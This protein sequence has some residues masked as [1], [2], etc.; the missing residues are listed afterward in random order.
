MQLNLSNINA[1][2]EVLTRTVILS[3]THWLRRIQHDAEQ[4]EQSFSSYVPVFLESHAAQLF[5]LIKKAQA[6]PGAH[7]VS[8]DLALSLEPV[9]LLG[10]SYPEWLFALQG[11]AVAMNNGDPDEP[12]VVANLW[13]A[14]GRTY[15]ELGDAKRAVTSFRIAQGLTHQQGEAGLDQQAALLHRIGLARVM[16]LRLD[17]ARAAAR[18]LMDTARLRQDPYSLALA[19]I[20]EAE[21]AANGY[22]PEQAYEHGQQAF[23]YAQ[24]LKDRA[25][26]LHALQIM[27]DACRLSGQSAAA[28]RTLAA[29]QRLAL[30]TGHRAWVA[31]IEQSLGALA[32]FEQDFS[33]AID[34]LSQARHYFQDTGSKASLASSTHSLGM[35]YYLSG[36]FAA[37]ARMFESAIKLWKILE[38]DF[39]CHSAGVML[40]VARKRSGLHTEAEEDYRCGL[41]E[42]NENAEHSCDHLRWSIEHGI[43]NGLD[44]LDNEN[45]WVEAAEGHSQHFNGSPGRCF[46]EKRFH[47]SYLMRDQR[48]QCPWFRDTGCFIQ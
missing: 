45:A 10:G 31:I 4:S 25:A 2:V 35:A 9:I 43:S 46:F 40:G 39:A 36:D 48:K 13:R 47:Q 22:H 12:L 18:E 21:V 1:M 42:L 33:G 30:E 17:E 37:A 6:L 28:K 44:S 15:Y 38:N 34:L 27:G 41:S 32:L 3:V 29:A 11:L 8:A 23:I 7:S 26:S 19:H 20:L 16:Q 24:H 5:D 14:V